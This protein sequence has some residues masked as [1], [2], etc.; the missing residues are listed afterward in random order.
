MSQPARRS[1][2]YLLIA[3]A[4]LM[5]AFAL[6]AV[7]LTRLPLY[8]D[9]MQ[10]ISRAQLVLQGHPYVGDIRKFAFYQFLSLYQPTG[11]ESPWITRAVAAVMGTLTAAACIGLGRVLA[12]RRAGLAA[13]LLYALLPFAV[14]HDRTTLVEPLQAALLALSLALMVRLA[15]RPRLWT[16]LGIGLLLGW[17]YLSKISTLPYLALP[18]LAAL[19]LGRSRKKA[20]PLSALSVLIALGVILPVYQQIVRALAPRYTLL[21]LLANPVIGIANGTG[22]APTL[23]RDLRDYAEIMRM[24]AGYVVIGLVALSALWFVAARRMR[25]A[26]LFLA[27]PALGFAVPVILSGGADA[28]VMVPRYFVPTVAPLVAL[29]ALSLG[30]LLARLEALRVGIGQWAAVI[31][32]ALALIPALRFDVT[33]IRNPASAPLYKSQRVNFISGWGSGTG[34][35][36]IA[37][38]LIGESDGGRVPIRVLGYNKS[39]LWMQAYLGPRLGTQE[40]LN[41]QSNRQRERIARWLGQGDRVYFLVENA[42]DL[43]NNPPHFTQPEVAGVFETA[44]YGPMTLARVAGVTGPAAED[45]YNQRVAAPEQMRADYEMLAASLSGLGDDRSIIIF[46]PGHAALLGELTGREVRALRIR[47]WP[48]GVETAEEALDDLRLGEGGGLVDAILVD[49]AAATPDQIAALALNRHLYRTGEEWYGLL[50]HISYV[51]GPADPPLDTL[52]AAYE[53]VIHLKRGLVLDD[54]VRAGGHV[55]IALA[56]ETE[57]PIAD[58]FRVYAHVMDESGTLRAQ[59]DMIPGGG[60]FPMTY[61]EPGVEV[62][63]RF[64]VTLPADLP[65]GRYEVRVGIYH[66]GNGLRLPVTAGADVGPDYVVV[67]RFVVEG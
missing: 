52:D 10:Y 47:S 34:Q 13:G 1:D 7:D 55:R 17:A 54:T 61:W 11:P 48:A 27:I 3:V 16:A 21:T 15:R 9:E 64:A 23:A 22:G 45:V 28:G 51:T 37:A 42:D 66:P 30:M 31:L 29:A 24:Y 40:Y 46:P 6:R 5:V 67:G 43:L 32:L 49:E 14:F 44:M 50:H 53:Q 8:F 60:L 59:Y 33:L 19:L 38:Y 65:P 36:E 41:T 26:L 4:I 18:P 25:G 39:V 35:P 56:W 12:D 20:L 63:D 58:S 57:S 62:V 2:P